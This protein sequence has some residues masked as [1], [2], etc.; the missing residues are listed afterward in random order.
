MNFKQLTFAREYRSLTQ[1]EL[2]EAIK[3]LSQSNL[4]KFER[5]IGTLSDQIQSR[6]IE[7]LDFPIEFFQKKI[8]N[9]LEHAH[10]R[11][12][13][14]VT[15]SAITLFESQCK[16]VGYIVDQMSELIEWPEFRL[17]AL[18]VEEGFAPTYIANYTRNL[19]GLKKD[20]P[21]RDVFMLLERSGIII[22]EISTI[23][24]F[25]GISFITDK[26]YPV[27][28]VNKNF[29]NDRKRR[30]LIHELGHILMHNEGNYAISSYRDEKYRESETEIFTSEFLMP[31]AEI[32][33]SL[34][35]LRMGDLLPLKQY[36]L[37]SMSSII[38][39]AK[40]L[41]Y[42]D[43][44]RYRF[45]SIE[46]SRSGQSKN[47]SGEVYID[48]PLYFQQAFNL[49]K[50]DLEYSYSDMSKAFALPVNLLEDIFYF[51]RAVSLK[52]VK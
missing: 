16:L 19:L 33:R 47:E 37:V 31:E 43:K 25:D 46:M 23:E 26:G 40:D 6:I 36:W 17:Q 52:R 2:S 45:F 44:E 41:G 4:S 27:I 24:K 20:D 10:Y 29:S 1:T 14:T 15:K 18:N 21:V 42:I 12:R 5:G 7:Y 11:K 13:S 22:Y 8:Y 49:I 9:N 34:Q 32:G 50:N 39:R 35:Y 3:G 48:K 38:R 30:T 51:D 28:I